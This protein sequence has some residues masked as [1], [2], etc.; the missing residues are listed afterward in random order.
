MSAR[1]RLAQTYYDM[2]TLL[3]AGI[4]ILRSFSTLIEGRQG[5]MKRTLEQMRDSLSQGSSLSEAMDE[6]PKTFPEMDRMLIQA[7]ETAGSTGN[8]LQMLSQWH[9]FVHRITW[10][11]LGGVAYPLFSLHAAAFIVPGPDLVL[12]KIGLASYLL[13]AL[14]ILSI[15]YVPTAMVMVILS[16]GPKANPLRRFLDRIALIIPIFGQA[17]YHLSVS[18]HARAFGMLYKAG[19]PITECTQRA[20]RATGNL[21]MADLFAG[22]V[23]SVQAGKMACDG[24]SKRLP[25]EYRDL[26]RIGEES[27]ELDKTVDKVAEIATD[28]AN[29]YFREFARWLPVVVWAAIAAVLVYMIFKTASQIPSFSGNF[30]F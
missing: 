15:V 18:R 5:S 20:H 10:Q 24:F 3:D 14:K 29:L 1:R 19:V 22:S 7:G 11:V 23:D 21:V 27:G 13:Q 4:P 17:M 16:L 2:A 30:D 9:E 25:A 8:S 12:G 6:H 28:R 26:W